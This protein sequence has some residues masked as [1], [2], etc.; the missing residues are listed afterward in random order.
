MKNIERLFPTIITLLLLANITFANPSVLQTV[1]ISTGID[2][3]QPNNSVYPANTF[4][5]FWNIISGPGVSPG[6]AKTVANTAWKVI[7]NT[8]Y[9]FAGTNNSGTYE[10]ER[11]FCLQNPEKAS[12]SLQLRADNKAKV[13]LNTYSPILTTG[14]SND[15]FR[16]PRPVEANI[17]Q[18][19]YAGRNCIRVQLENESGPTGFDLNAVLQGFGAQDSAPK[20]CCRATKRLFENR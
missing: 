12:L 18:G 5:G 11:C 17:T 20:E 8:S 9:I 7:P 3:S 1:N 10:F 15:T 4:D 16:T 6:Q 2:V 13:F 14:T 19:F